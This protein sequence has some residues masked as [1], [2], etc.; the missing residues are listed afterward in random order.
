MDKDILYLN[1]PVNFFKLK[2]G[3][4]EV[5]LETVIKILKIKENVM[6]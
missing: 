3:D 1:G 4:K 2:N 6:N 5:Y